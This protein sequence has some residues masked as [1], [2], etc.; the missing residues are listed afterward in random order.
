MGETGMGKRPR[1]GTPQ[2]GMTSKVSGMLEGWGSITATQ[3]AKLTG[4]SKSLQGAPKAA[5]IASALRDTLGSLVGFLQDQGTMISDLMSEVVKLEERIVETESRQ[6]EEEEKIASL[7]KSRVTK[8]QMDSR[9][10]MTEK[11]KASSKQ[12][13]LF[14][15]DFKKEVSDRKELMATAKNSILERISESRRAK[16]EELIRTATMQVLARANTKRRVK[17][18]DTEVWTAPVLVTVEDRDTRWELEDTLRSNGLYPTF[19][20][21]RDILDSVKTMRENIVKE[22]PEDKYMVRIRPEE[23]AGSWHI[24]A[25]VRPQEGNERFKLGATWAVPP[26][27]P[28]I[29]DQVEDWAKPKGQ[30]GRARCY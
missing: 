15:I 1:I 5:D 29:R 12:F 16:Y 13:K 26:L 17:D 21:D 4:L 8:N 9:Q 20:W 23:R 3:V 30:S 25:D 11:V 28:A 2:K 6:D 19:H 7:E 18:S 22:Y 24:K 14:D 27:D 10:D